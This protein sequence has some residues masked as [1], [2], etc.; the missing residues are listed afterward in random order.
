MLVLPGLATQLVVP[1]AGG[2]QVPLTLDFFSSRKPCPRLRNLR[3]F[4]HLKILVC[5]FQSPASERKSLVEEG[6]SALVL[7]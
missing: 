4:Q 5:Y 6:S 3:L 2:G 7:M 1:V